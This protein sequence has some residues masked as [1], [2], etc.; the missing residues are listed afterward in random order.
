MKIVTWEN[1]DSSVVSDEAT[2]RLRSLS[3]LCRVANAWKKYEIYEI[4]K[5]SFFLCSVSFFFCG[6]NFVCFGSVR[7]KFQILIRL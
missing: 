6:R 4:G 1:T 3:T 2:L 7:S 5:L